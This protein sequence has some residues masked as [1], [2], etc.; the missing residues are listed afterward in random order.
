MLPAAFKVIKLTFVLFLLVCAKVLFLLVLH[1][2]A[3]FCI[4]LLNGRY[5]VVKFQ[6]SFFTHPSS[7]LYYFEYFLTIS[8]IAQLS[9]MVVRNA[10]LFFP[11]VNGTTGEGMSLTVE[12][13]KMLARE[14]VEK[15]KGKW[16]VIHFYIRWA[17]CRRRLGL[18]YLFTFVSECM[19]VLVSAGWM[20]WLCMSA[21][22]VWKIPK[23]WW[24][25]DDPLCRFKYRWSS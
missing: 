15:S 12:E 11:A 16:V 18:V 21:A 14:W 6:H 8:Q 20:R 2:L 19:C 9:A 23:N 22:W 24:V 17:S 1:T 13:R 10:R 4:N 3:S 25:A 7:C 5:V